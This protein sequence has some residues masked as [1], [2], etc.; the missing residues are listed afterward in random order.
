[1]TD[2]LKRLAELDSQ[3]P[4]IVK[5][6]KKD[7]KK[8]LKSEKK[9]GNKDK[10]S[11]KKE[12]DEGV[13]MEQM[14]MDSLRLLAGMTKKLKE[15]GIETANPYG[16]KVIKECGPTGMMGLDIAKP[17]TPA[18]VNV[19]AGSGDELGSLLKTIMSLA[20][21]KPVTQND[22]PI[23]HGASAPMPPQMGGE[24][25]MKALI[26][27]VTDEPESELDTMNDIEDGGEEGNV[28]DEDEGYDNSPHPQMKQDPMR[29]FG[30]INSGDHRNRQSNLPKANP[31]DTT[32]SLVK[33]LYSEYEKFISE[34]GPD[35]KDIPAWKRKEK[36][37]DWKVSSKDL[38]K[39]KDSRISDPKTLAKNS[40][41]KVAEALRVSVGGTRPNKADAGASPE[42]AQRA[43]AARNRT[44]AS[45]KSA[46]AQDP[47]FR[48]SNMQGGQFAHNSAIKT[49]HSR[50]AQRNKVS[51]T[52]VPESKD[53]GKPGKNFKKIANKASK[54]YGS[55]EAGNKVAGAVK[56]KLAKK[57][58]L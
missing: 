23:D 55:K 40:G 8:D 22:M 47:Q 37:G 3:N 42:D 43:T 56:A 6:A 24:P 46:R 57:G 16:K 49:A 20:G 1:M 44:A 45:A 35:K 29:Q 14:S 19:T 58:K 34:S 18:S 2:V 17:S 10:K 30:D 32:E 36:G 27:V 4:N 11:D 41:K 51:A 15:H 54:E 48:G 21:V 38:E 31:Q 28:E 12:V 52:S 26:D 33:N 7:D 39:E 53:E 9:E 25:D 50:D 5:E 13:T